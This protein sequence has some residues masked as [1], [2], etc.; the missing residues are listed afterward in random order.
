MT[1]AAPA[2]RTVWWYFPEG[3]DYSTQSFIRISCAIEPFANVGWL[4]DING[5]TIGTIAGWVT[6]ALFVVIA[7]VFTI[8]YAIQIVMDG[9]M[10]TLRFGGWKIVESGP[11]LHY[12]AGAVLV[13]F[14]MLVRRAETGWTTTPGRM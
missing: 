6:A 9:C 4:I 12:S 3:P 2:L 5:E 8:P 13:M 14:L 10:D 11:I 7:G 1:L